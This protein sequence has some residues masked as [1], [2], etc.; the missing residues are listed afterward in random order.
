MR[1]VSVN[2]SLPRDFPWQG[3][4]VRT[5]IVKEPVK[6]PVYLHRLHLDGDGVADPRYHGGPDKAV[7]AYSFEHY[8]YWAGVLGRH[9]MPFGQ[10]G[11][12]FTV[13]G[14]LETDVRL[15][16]VYSVG[17]AR[18]MVTQPRTPCQKLGMKMGSLRFVKEFSASG[19]IGYYLRVV[20]EGYLEAG[21]AITRV[22]S[23][24]ARPTVADAF[25]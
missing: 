1:L 10:F 25:G 2:V 20:E 18:V 12:N 13:E 4:L 14:M 22:A 8:A 3:R 6:G 21:D 17:R 15:G 5:G 16:D 19:R 24:P 7:Y 11:E 9:D 23:D